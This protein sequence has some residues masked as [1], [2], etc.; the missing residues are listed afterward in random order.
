MN[1]WKGLRDSGVGACFGRNSHATCQNRVRY[2]NLGDRAQS[3]FLSVE[4]RAKII[5]GVQA[6]IAG[7]E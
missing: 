4:G 5:S 7:Q 1:L 6:R 2:R 3:D